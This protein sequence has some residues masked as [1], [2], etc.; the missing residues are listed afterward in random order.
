MQIRT[1][2]PNLIVEHEGKEIEFTL[3]VQGAIEMIEKSG[4]PRDVHTAL[5]T[6]LAGVTLLKAMQMP[7]LMIVEILLSFY[8][9]AA[10]VLRP[11]GP[12]S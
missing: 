2:L 12:A 6:M 9:E 5:S 4:L 8:D 1:K 7:P 10:P 3:D 11:S